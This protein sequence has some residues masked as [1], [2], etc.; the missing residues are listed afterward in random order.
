[1]AQTLLSDGAVLPAFGVLGGLSDFPVGSWIDRDGEIEDFDTPGKVAGYAVEEGSVVMI[2]SAG[3]GSYGDPL[4]RDPERVAH[5]V[6]EGYVSA[7]GSA[8]AVRARTGCGRS[9]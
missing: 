6:R 7:N 4:D 2:R 5:D 1:V 3:G 8:R 9:G